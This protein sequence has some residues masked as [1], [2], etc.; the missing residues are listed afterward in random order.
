MA[1]LW[2]IYTIT[3]LCTFDEPVRSGLDELKQREQLQAQ[4]AQLLLLQRQQQQQQQQQPEQLPLGKN[5]AL[6]EKKG[7][8][9]E[10]DATV[11]MYDDENDDYCENADDDT[12]SVG[13]S[14]AA[15]SYASSIGIGSGGSRGRSRHGG[16]DRKGPNVNN[17][18][19]S[20]SLFSGWCCY[21][22]S[23]KNDDGGGWGFTAAYCGCCRHITVAV[24]LTMSLIFMKRIALEC[25]VG[26][27]S[28]ITKNRYGWSIQN[29][30]TLQFA[31]GVLI[32]PVSALAGWLSTKYEDRRLALTFLAV[33]A[34]GMM[35]LIDYADLSSLL[36]WSKDSDDAEKDD[37]NDR[38]YG[39]VGPNLYI[40]GTLIAFAGIWATE[41]YV[42][43]MMS[44]VVP[45]ALA[46]GTFNSGLLAT[47][48]G[49]GGRAVGDLFITFMGLISLR[50]LLN[51]LM[52][53]ALAL[54]VLSMVLIRVHYGR[55]KV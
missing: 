30:G 6:L 1:L 42:A 4:Q 21:Y 41:S 45:S 2:T 46:A 11:A 34:T 12:N 52:V 44:K 27:T 23:S 16:K 24:A 15:Q 9:G 5:S 32:I 50:H 37:N 26:S 7:K 35:I 39:S 51:L 49:T 19:T 43:S 17:T 8:E 10:E 54:V 53:P 13:S 55:L 3:I 28:I 14:M 40:V 29:V 36:L 18:T 33:T 38:P 20:S 22:D 31:N 25:I 48:V 47:L